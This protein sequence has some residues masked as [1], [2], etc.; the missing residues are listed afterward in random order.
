MAHDPNPFPPA[1][2]PGYSYRAIG[3]WC[4]LLICCFAVPAIVAT[5]DS[6]PA[7]K[8]DGSV[9]AQMRN[10]KYRFSDKVSVQINTLQGAFVPVGDNEMPVFDN[11][12][13]FKI[14]IDS[15]EIAISPQDLANLLNDYV[16]ARPGS[17]L[18]G[19]SVST[20]DKG[21]I[22]VKGKLKDKGGIP[23]ESEGV[24]T[25]TPDGRL[26]LHADRMKALKIPVKGLMDAFGIEVSDLI[27]SGKVPGVTAEENDLIFDLQQI[28][29]PPHIEGKVTKVRVEPDTIVQTFAADSKAPVDTKPVPKLQGNYLALQGNKLRFGKLTMEDSD[30]IL[31][32]VNPVGRLD[33]FLDHYK[34]Q[35]AAGYT[36]IST[37]Y[38]VRAYI[39]GYEK[40]GQTKVAAT[41]TKKD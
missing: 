41:P 5:Q 18:S 13:S 8:G 35:L 23:F 9:R 1:G 36:K 17:Q 38:Q 22:K 33:F 20:T 3:A 32:D 19:L 30:L 6:K 27:K 12:N 7:E 39:K 28:L 21:H 37:S 4:A 10:V 40:L 16:F 26:R 2:K 14:R 31:Y 24:L 29:P 15:A 25:P 34:E 11:K